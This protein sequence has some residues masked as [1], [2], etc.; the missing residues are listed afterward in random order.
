MEVSISSGPGKF[1]PVL[2]CK[3][4][5]AANADTGSVLSP[6]EPGL[7]F[8]QSFFLDLIPDYTES[9]YPVQPVIT[10]AELREYI[11]TMDTDQEIRSF[12]CSFG[13]CTLN[14]TRQTD[15]RTEEVLQAIETLINYSISTMKPVYKSFRSS[16]LR[17]MQSMFIHNCMMSMSAS[18]AAFH[19]MRDSITA[20]QLL[21][22]DNAD[23]MA[24]LSPPERSRRQRLYWQA[25][26][27]ERFSAILDY[28]TVVLPPLNVLP[29]ADPTIPLQVHEGFIQII[30]LFRLL[31]PEFLQNWI[32][33]QGNVTSTWIEEKS[34]ELEGDEESN[35]RELANLSMVS[36]LLYTRVDKSGSLLIVLFRLDATC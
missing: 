1:G 28:R 19:Y 34:R 3:S 32:G 8:G 30:K 11:Q 14:L 26:I 18:D 9:V 13:A 31:D 24:Q 36:R 33:S 4:M 23:T 25:F 16:V 6:M 29:E 15:K 17:A 12:V 5:Y 2:T 10:E 27:H 20:V 21:R 7:Q 35:A 22:V